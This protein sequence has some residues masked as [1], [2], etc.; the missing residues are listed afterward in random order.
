MPTANFMQV[1]DESTNGTNKS[2]QIQAHCHP[3]GR[4]DWGTWPNSWPTIWP[5]K[6]VRQFPTVGKYCPFCGE[7]KEQSRSY[8]CESCQQK[9]DD[10]EKVVRE[11]T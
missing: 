6:V 10:A 2:G 5:P 1:L 7:K 11:L 3:H 8:R 9:Y 4:Y